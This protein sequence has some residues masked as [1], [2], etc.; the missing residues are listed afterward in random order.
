MRSFR[1]GPCDEAFYEV[2]RRIPAG[3]VAT[4]GQIAFLSGHPG[5]A[6]A[7]GNALHRNPDPDRTPCFRVVDAS[8]RL[9]GAFAFGGAGEQQR[10]LEKDGITVNNGR[11]DLDRFGWHPLG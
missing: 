6:R 7:V 2:V 3:H 4:Y 1:P 5:A 8:G 10:R 9:S 11:V